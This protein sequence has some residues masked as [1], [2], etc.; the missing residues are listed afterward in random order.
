MIITGDRKKDKINYHY[1]KVCKGEPCIFHNPSKHKMRDWP[2]N[3]RTDA[4]AAPLI[5]RICKHGVGHPDP[6]S[7]YYMNK[8]EGFE[9]D[10][11]IKYGYGVHGC[12][13]CC[14]EDNDE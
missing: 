6:D 7:V 11:A 13:G 8:R 12:D 3:L 1:E 10:K 14:R 4:F 2:M 5:E 9:G